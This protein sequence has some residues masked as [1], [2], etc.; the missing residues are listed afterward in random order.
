M[1]DRTTPSSQN[2]KRQ[3]ASPAPAVGERPRA[4][5]QP[6]NPHR[7][8]RRA[9]GHGEG[10]FRRLAAL[11]TALVLAASQL[12]ALITCSPQPALAATWQEG[13]LDCIEY[14]NYRGYSTFRLSSGNEG[15][16]AQTYKS[17]PE[18][19][20]FHEWAWITDCTAQDCDGADPYA[21]AYLLAHVGANRDRGGFDRPEASADLAK[22][23]L[24]NNIAI[25]DEGM[26]RLTRTN[27]DTINCLEDSGNWDYGS[28]RI[29]RADLARIY[30]LV[31]DAR[32]HAGRS[33][34]W[35]AS[36]K[37]WKSPDGKVQNIYEVFRVEETGDL[38][39]VKASSEPLLT[40]GNPSYSLAGAV[41]TVFSAD[42]DAVA[43]LVTDAQG[44][45]SA[46]GL[47][48]GTYQ[49]RETTA[50]PGY[51]LDEKTYEVEV[52]GGDP[53]RLNVTDEP[54]HAV[55]LA[56]RKVDARTGEAVAQGDASLAGAELTVRYFAGTT[57]DLDLSG[58]PTRAWVVRT[59]ADGTTALDDAHLVRG[60]ELYRTADGTVAL[61]LGCASVEE[62]KAPAGY[63]A[64]PTVHV[65]RIED[66]DGG[67]RVE[68]GAVPAF[69]E[70]V[71]AGGVRVQKV[72]Y[73]TGE[74]LPQ[75]DGALAGAEF[76][77]V[78]ASAASVLVNGASVAPGQV[79]AT[80][81]T[82]A[83]GA[84]STAADALPFGT[85]E[86]RETRPSAGYGI[87]DRW[88]QRFSV[89]QDGVV[90]DLS[91]TP[92]PEPVIRGGVGVEKLDRDLAAGQAQGSATLAGARVRV[93]NAS[94]APVVVGGVLYQ[95]EDT[96]AELVTDALGKAQTTADAL[97]YGTYRL[98][99]AEAPV[100]Y[101]ANTEWSATLEVR[102]QG[103]VAMAAGA[104]A[105]TDAV[106]R[107]G[108]RVQKL[109]AQTGTAPQGDA[110]L[111]GAVLEVVNRSER[112]VVVAGATV[113]PGE[114][115]LSIETNEQGLA[116]SA[117]D[118]LP[119]GSYEVREAKAPAGYL[120]NTSW[121]KT[122]S[123]DAQGQ[124]A[125]LT[126]A[127][128]AL[129]DTVARGGVALQKTDRELAS[130]SALGAATLEGAIVS[131]VNRSAAAVT[132]GDKSYAPG[133]TVLELVT[134]AEGRAA[135]DGSA[136]PFGTYEARETRAPAGYL[137]NGAW[138]RT[139]E[140]REDG[141][142]VDLTEGECAL[143]DQV[144]RGDLSLVKADEDTQRR[145]ARVPFALTSQT[146]G[147]S[148]VL[149]TD[150]NGMLDTSAS[151][152][153]HGEKTNQNDRAL[154]ADGSVDDSL[155]DPA[156]GVWFSGLAEGTTEPND[157]LGALPYD[158][159]L[160]EELPCK[161]NEGYRMVETSVTITRDGICLDLGTID[162]KLVPREQPALHT[163]LTDASGNHS[164][165]A[166][167]SLTLT[168]KV[169]CT[170]L[171]V[172]REYTLV[173]ILH[174]RSGGGAD[175]GELLD[176]NGDAVVSRATFV[177]EKPE[178]EVPVS[179]CID[180][181]RLAG[182]DLVA[183]EEL[184]LEGTPVAEHADINDQGQTVHVDEPPAPEPEPEEPPMTETPKTPE[185]PEKKPVPQAGDVSADALPVVATGALTC[186]IGALLAYRHRRLNR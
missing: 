176:A 85:Y 131:V 183:F 97:P 73:D 23:L 72:D 92:V 27:K 112:P 16:C 3:R 164:V 182:M 77:I 11:A 108:L 145:M 51:A 117:T 24:C 139:F 22:S 105:L 128:D 103:T 144:V 68:L 116:E 158:A 107:G 48:V 153:S 88:S 82:D 59:D 37:L 10:L 185:T 124:V 137:L 78:N 52:P 95:P 179:F 76:T 121:S 90:V 146:T 64:D 114:V 83:S 60:D 172:G 175:A 41:Y 152:T 71:L 65:L 122:F 177:A 150:E 157:D 4:A 99:E 26:V 170:G 17:I 119:F 29:T 100:G 106:V 125:D 115:A 89:Q 174:V 148:H 19:R 159:Y 34:W 2:Q 173:G 40:A 104:G 161:A 30:E 165:E 42:G 180:T 66:G 74:A 5:A 70:Q 138:A 186:S 13:E 111:T 143:S 18:G 94:A 87:N 21:M 178:Q 53:V 20:T 129:A 149:V 162:N 181:S 160:L 62:T 8:P 15:V 126:H 163:T 84:A 140:V 33:G 93:V 58:S 86:V 151:W 130:G 91:T 101:L 110:T 81:V 120:A 47:P 75:G 14:I 6:E 79:A 154:T 98:E 69:E 32:A 123:I 96:V 31:D 49:V 1:Q 166:A 133:E 25:S 118:T 9:T 167:E 56:L 7:R 50:A 141:Q 35:N 39:L 80:I 134:D 109:D 155:L 46:T 36:A 132:V 102:E 156:A 38:E 147:E 171:E 169:S 135:S 44:R 43:T 12:L 67:A 136:L 57:A 55:G 61:P 45:A 28:G 54:R 127:D 184:R 168:D 142:T 113:A 63:R